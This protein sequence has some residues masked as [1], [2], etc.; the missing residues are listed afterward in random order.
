MKRLTTADF[1]R[2]AGEIL[3]VEIV[4]PNRHSEQLLVR[5]H[6]RT[7]AGE[8]GVSILKIRK[9]LARNTSSALLDATR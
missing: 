9:D 4:N 1:D 2:A 8:P 6:I 5:L 3:W 7:S